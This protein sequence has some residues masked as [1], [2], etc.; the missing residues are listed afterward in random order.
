MHFPLTRSQFLIVRSPC[1]VGRNVGL[2]RQLTGPVRRAATGCL[3][4]TGRVRSSIAV[5]VTATAPSPALLLAFALA[6][7]RGLGGAGA[8]VLRAGLRLL[9]TLLL[10]RRALVRMTLA[11]RASIAL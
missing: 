4:V 3:G 7:R 2:G 8:R 5:A 1:K 10:M 9:R 6:G 11:A